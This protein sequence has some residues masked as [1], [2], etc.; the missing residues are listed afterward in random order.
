MNRTGERTQVRCQGESPPRSCFQPLLGL[1]SL[2]PH[3]RVPLP[4]VLSQRDGA[5]SCPGLDPTA[6]VPKVG[7]PQP[8]LP[9]PFSIESPLPLAPQASHGGFVTLSLSFSLSPHPAQLRP[10]Q[11]K[12]SLDVGVRATV[13]HALQEVLWNR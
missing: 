9:E 4:A 13:V 7:S 1:F 3:P 6:Q 12:L 8:C 5:A 10:Q 11:E 2:S